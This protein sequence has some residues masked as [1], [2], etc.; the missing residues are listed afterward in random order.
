MSTY[1]STTQ[2]LY[3]LTILPLAIISIYSLVYLQISDNDYK[4]IF[5]KIIYT[6]VTFYCFI[7]VIQ[8]VSKNPVSNHIIQKIKLAI[9]LSLFYAPYLKEIKKVKILSILLTFIILL[10]ILIADKL[11]ID[12]D[13]H[14]LIYSNLYK[15]IL[16]MNT[17]LINISIV[18]DIYM[19]NEK[20][21][22]LNKKVR[23]LLNLLLISTPSILHLIILMKGSFNI[24][25]SE[26]I[27]ILS[28]VI[29][30]IVKY[31]D[32]NESSLLIKTFDEVSK[33]SS[34]YLF[35]LDKNYSI[36]FANR[37]AIS[38]D[39][40]NRIKTIDIDNLTKLFKHEA[41][42]EIDSA[43]NKYIA[44]KHE[45]ELIKYYSYNI[46]D[47]KKEKKTLS[48][49]LSIEDISEIMDLS[50]SLH[51]KKIRTEYFN[52]KLEQY[53]KIV[54]NIEKEKQVN[55]LLEKI[56]ENREQ[57]MKDLSKRLVNLLDKIDDT[58]FENLIEDTIQNTNNILI[59]VRATVSKF[60][61]N[62]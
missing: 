35:I 50:L 28:F 48:Y 15:T 26:I 31:F 39:L 61:E 57:Q 43:N 10:F 58:N 38:S 3:V 42:E 51:K 60:R 25:Y 22:F 34:K 49:V 1:Y 53:S 12:S 45:K 24:L 27:L 40:F 23:I 17:I 16:L 30:S 32:N 19:S 52:Q 54:Y 8:S 7:S 55:K 46:L 37:S 36:I 2:F 47:V 59:D 5:L 62:Y 41:K 29:I 9:F 14:N 13:Y 18:K 6:L 44:V 4:T 33:N 11:I 21:F 20:P 56:I